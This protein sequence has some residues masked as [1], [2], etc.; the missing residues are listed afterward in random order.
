M[1]HPDNPKR[2]ELAYAGRT[3]IVTGSAG[4]IGGAIAD[5]MR[6]DGV[7]VV[8]I[9]K[10]FDKRQNLGSGGVDFPADITDPLRLQGIAEALDIAG[11]KVDLLILGAGIPQ[12]KQGAVS[13]KEAIH[14]T[15]VNVGGTRNS[16]EAFAQILAPHATV[17]VI[18]SDL[19]TAPSDRVTVPV[20]ARTKREVAEY[21]RELA[22]AHPEK[23]IV[24][25]LPGAVDTRLLWTGKTAEDIERIKKFADTPAHFARTLLTQVVPKTSD[26]SNGDIVRIDGELVEK[27]MI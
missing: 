4:G 21:A 8:G 6:R 10:V 14:I 15:K 1:S 7:F 19:I 12:S 9:D 11:K 3:A 13:E 26:F 17:V 22:K 23:R 2:S 16:F 24:T 27:V 18:S 20:Y 5:Y 25:V